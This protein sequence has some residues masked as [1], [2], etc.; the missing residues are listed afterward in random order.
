MKYLTIFS[1]LLLT[2]SFVFSQQ[3]SGKNLAQDVT[4]LV[5]YWELSNIGSRDVDCKG[6]PFEVTNVNSAIDFE[7]RPALIKLASID[8]KSKNNVDEMLSM[9]KMIPLA[10][11]DGKSVL[12]ATYEKLKQDSFT[13]YGKQGG[14]A[15][16]SSSFRTVVQQRKLAIKNFL[17]K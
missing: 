17:T 6:T 16:L 13:T 1:A 5:G 15:S 4:A 7:V 9:I 2:Q 8:S 12:Q 3:D 14:C 11:K 10:T